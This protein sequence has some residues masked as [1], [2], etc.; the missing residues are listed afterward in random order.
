MMSAWLIPVM[1]LA[2]ALAVDAVAVAAAQGACYRPSAGRSAEMALAFG[3]A[4]GV[5]PLGGFFLGALAVGAVEAVD[6]WI[7]LALLGFLGF[8]MLRG[9]FGEDEVVNPLR[10]RTL[11]LAALATSID[12]FAA[13]LTLP[14]LDAPAFAACAAIAGVT[15]LLSYAAVRLGVRAGPR[16]GDYAE[17]VGGVLLIL[18]GLRIFISH[19]FLGA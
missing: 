18:I 11:L 17:R 7:A 5:M 4:Q 1:I 12:A 14:L 13:G 19:Q 9:S 3:L 16:L 6:H 2:V 10:G 8:Q 15:A